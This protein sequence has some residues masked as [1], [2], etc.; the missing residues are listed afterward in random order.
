MK[1]I[2][3]LLKTVGDSLIA[4]SQFIVVL[5]FYYKKYEYL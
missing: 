2:M 5:I 3:N 4:S 1:T